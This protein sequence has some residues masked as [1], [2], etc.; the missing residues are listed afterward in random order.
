MLYSSQF[1]ALMGNVPSVAPPQETLINLDP[2]DPGDLGVTPQV[3][4]TQV[5]APTLS[6]VKWLVG[7]EGAKTIAFPFNATDNNTVPGY[8]HGDT[9]NFTGYGTGFTLTKDSSGPYN[10]FAQ[11]SNGSDIFTIGTETRVQD[12]RY[13]IDGAGGTGPVAYTLLNLT[14]GKGSIAATFD[15]PGDRLI[16]KNTDETSTTNSGAAIF[17]GVAVRRITLSPQNPGDLG[18]APANW[19]TNVGTIGLADVK[20]S[21]FDGNWAPRTS[22]TWKAVKPV[23][24]AYVLTVPFVA[25]GD[26]LMVKSLDE[27]VE[28]VSGDVAFSQVART[29]TLS[30]QNPG[31]LGTAPK[32]WTT[33]ATVGGMAQVKWA[34][35]DTNFNARAAWTVAPVSGGT[36]SITANFIAAGDRLVVKSEDDAIEAI[37][38]QVLFNTVPATPTTDTTFRNDF[39]KNMTVGINIERNTSI[40]LSQAYYTKLKSDSNATWIR[41]FAPRKPPMGGWGT[42]ADFQNFITSSRNAIAA[43]F[44]VLLAL[45]DVLEPNDVEDSGCRPHIQRCARLLAA[46]NLDPRKFMV[47]PINEC[48]YM[49]NDYWR[50]FVERFCGDLRA[51]LPNHLLGASGANWS[52]PF[53]LV[54]GKFTPLADKRVLYEWHSYPW[55]GEK[56]FE[57]QKIQTSISAWETANNVRCFGGEYGKNQQQ[58]LGNEGV[59]QQYIPGAIDAASRGCGQQRPMFWTITNGAWWRMNNSNNLDLTPAIA[60]ALKAGDAHIRAQSYFGT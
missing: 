10:F 21:V 17:S 36:T 51:E 11:G 60:T 7:I 39:I 57:A 43:G 32:N 56:L 38:G 42:D 8:N 33:T 53:V 50:P 9:I 3:W 41:L 22:P 59:K 25:A 30:P 24:G 4:N 19:T 34:V 55:E 16:V 44:S 27:T 23:N 15:R 35:F 31:D 47:N 5:D 14:D 28:V 48:A 13:T 20:W 26:K 6:Q 37:S 52:D 2:A 45:T 18:T 1:M 58:S 29:I 54:D 46:A 40:G 49:T 12:V